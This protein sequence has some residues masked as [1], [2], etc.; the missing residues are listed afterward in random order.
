[1]LYKNLYNLLADYIGPICMRLNIA[2]FLEI[3]NVFEINKT[4][5]NQSSRVL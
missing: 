2:S 1:M 4:K 5:A 3:L